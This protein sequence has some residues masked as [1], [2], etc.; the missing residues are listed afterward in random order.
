M[1]RNEQVANRISWL[2]QF[3]DSEEPIRDGFK[4]VLKSAK[5]FCAFS[6]DGSFGK[7]SYNTLKKVLKEAPLGCFNKHP[8][9][10]NLDYF[11]VLR[12][13]C[14]SKCAAEASEELTRRSDY[15]ASEWR[16]LY[17]NALWHSSICSEAYISLRRDIQGLLSMNAIDGRLD[18]KRLEKI[19]AKSSDSYLKII[20]AE[21]EP[22]SPQLKIV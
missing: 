8:Y 21:P 4:E 12:Q 16:E 3:L 15:S 7:I 19:I 9:S 2:H 13:G 14:Y 22:Y 17:R 20:S 6:V 18:Y 10:S 5:D 1:K 11:L